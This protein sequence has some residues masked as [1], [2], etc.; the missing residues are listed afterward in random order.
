MYYGTEQSGFWKETTK[1]R[2]ETRSK[3]TTKKIGATKALGF[4]TTYRNTSQTTS[5]GWFYALG[6][7][8]EYKRY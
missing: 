2:S 5:K 8:Y 1:I 4:K 6:D 3:A 7:F